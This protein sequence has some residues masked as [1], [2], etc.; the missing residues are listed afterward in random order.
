ME[1]CKQNEI[2]TTCLFSGHDTLS[3]KLL[4]KRLEVTLL[5]IH[6]KL[7]CPFKNYSDSNIPLVLYGRAVYEALPWASLVAQMVKNLPSMQETLVRFLGRKDPL[8]KEMATHSSIL[9]WKIQWTEEPGVLQ[10]MG[11]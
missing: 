3:I 11:S 9:A 2:N 4:L 7:P 6:L 5:G 10:S 8:E 1:G